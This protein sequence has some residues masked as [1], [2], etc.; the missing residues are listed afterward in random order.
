M[1]DHRALSAA[2]YQRLVERRETIASAESLTG[3]AL[4]TALTET[5]GSAKVYRG[6]V[7]TYATDLKDAFLGVDPDLLAEQGP[8]HPDVARQMAEGIRDRAGATWGI[9][10]TG[11][12][13]PGDTDD[14]PEG[15]VYVGI[16]GPDGSDAVELRLPPGRDEVRATTVERALELLV[17]RLT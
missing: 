10:T 7:I 5:P 14:G 6:G 9:S 13:G 11:V 1:T 3:G 2:V 15:L 8:V 16:A 12:A 4:G 17:S